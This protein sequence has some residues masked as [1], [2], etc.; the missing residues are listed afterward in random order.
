M[1]IR[2]FFLCVFLSYSFIC[3]ATDDCLNK[4]P[5]EHHVFYQNNKSYN[6]SSYDCD[7]DKQGFL[8]PTILKVESND[9]NITLKN[10]IGH[11]GMTDSGVLDWNNKPSLYFYSGSST[12][13]EAYMTL[14]IENK[15]IFID[16]IYVSSR[17]KNL[18]NTQYSFCG[19]HRLVVDELDLEDLIPDFYLDPLFETTDYSVVD[20][21]SLNQPF[22]IFIGKID[23]LSIY[24][25]YLSQN[26]YMSEKY[27]IIVSSKDKQ[28][29]FKN[30]KVYQRMTNKS[31]FIGL[32]VITEN[33]DIVF[34]DKK[35]LLKLLNTSTDKRQCL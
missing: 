27:D 30:S 5:N 10:I 14:S 18:I 3:Y 2:Q 28:Y 21:Y 4:K 35:S 15:A 12:R 25:R 1:M 8:S 32:D 6:F 23:D 13:T 34:Y 9:F 20:Q 29:Q 24:R 33:H 31:D 11:K 17:L 26:D 16:C 19:Q 7:Y 22:D